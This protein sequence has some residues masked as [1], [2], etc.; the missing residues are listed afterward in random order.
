MCIIFWSEWTGSLV[1]VTDGVQSLEAM[2]YLPVP[3]LSTAL[4]WGT[5]VQQRCDVSL[6]I[7]HVK[8]NKIVCLNFINQTR[9]L[10]V[11]SIFLAWLWA[12]KPHQGNN[13]LLCNYP[14]IHLFSIPAFPAKYK[15][16]RSL[17][18]IW[19][20]WWCRPGVKLQLQG[21]MVCRLGMLLLGPSNVKV[22]GGEVEDLVERNSGVSWWFCAICL[23]ISNFFGITI[24][25][26]HVSLTFLFHSGRAGCFVGHW[27]SQRR[28][29]SSHKRKRRRCH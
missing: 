29:G 27:G 21:Q 17:Y 28:R 10:Q 7:W 2:E 3:A 16:P 23:K 26:S 19:L 13:V 20:I 11:E 6:C 4:R 24:H 8:I 14:S 12:E 9:G 15:N 5:G 18:S 1:Q 22:L 25:V